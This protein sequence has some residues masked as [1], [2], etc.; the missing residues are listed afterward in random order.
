MRSIISDNCFSNM[1]SNE[2]KIPP[3][4][5]NADESSINM[6]M[7]LRVVKQITPLG[8]SSMQ[9]LVL[10]SCIANEQTFHA[11]LKKSG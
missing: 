6:S 2:N 1:A 9:I 8:F 3:Y 4:C 5:I 7:V 11:Y 10:Q